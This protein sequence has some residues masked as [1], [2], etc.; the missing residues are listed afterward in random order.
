MLS[1]SPLFVLM[2]QTS[3]IQTVK[4]ITAKAEQICKKKLQNTK[5]QFLQSQNVNLFIKQNSLQ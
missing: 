1:K 5:H 2:I 3:T 4:S